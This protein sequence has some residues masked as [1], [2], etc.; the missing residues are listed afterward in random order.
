VDYIYVFRKDDFN[1]MSPYDDVIFSIMLAI[2]SGFVGNV[3]V[4]LHSNCY[5]I[6][7]LFILCIIF[8]GACMFLNNKYKVFCED[9]YF[10]LIAQ[11]KKL[12]TQKIKSAVNKR[13]GYIR[14][15]FTVLLVLSFGTM[16]SG[17]VFLGMEKNR[18]IEDVVSQC[19]VGM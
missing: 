4:S 16:L 19:I 5:K 15:I 3:Y 17:I 18:M 1:I 2:N 9:S 13:Y 6:I 12:S 14:V 10:T 11:K 8:I 7:L